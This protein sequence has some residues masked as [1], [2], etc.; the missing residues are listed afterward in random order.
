MV[1]EGQVHPQRRMGYATHMERIR[2]GGAR[3]S[4]P[5][6]ASAQLGGALADIYRS[7]LTIKPFVTSPRNEAE[8]RVS[9]LK[10]RQNTIST[11]DACAG[12]GIWRPLPWGDAWGGA[13]RPRS[14]G[15]AGTPL[16]TVRSGRAAATGRG[17]AGRRNGARRPRQGGRGPRRTRQGDR[18]PPPLRGPPGGAGGGRPHRRRHA[19][20]SGD[21]G[22]AR[23]A[24]RPRAGAGQRAPCF[25]AGQPEVVG[26]GGGAGT[27]PSAAPRSR[28]RRTG[29]TA[30]RTAAG[31]PQG[32]GVGVATRAGSGPSGSRPPAPCPAGS[33]PRRARAPYSRAGSAPNRRVVRPA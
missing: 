6:D 11:A 26:R 5:D 18:P 3:M 25:A 4:G 12:F 9:H 20:R 30:S 16:G 10:V 29:A 27:A 23:S 13:P 19:R 7:K 17:Q 8:L 33:S 22:S 21:Q 32:R 14:R 31:S 2:K 1:Q 15:V 24:G 28:A